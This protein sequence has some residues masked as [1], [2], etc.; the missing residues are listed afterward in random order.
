M[1]NQGFI[2]FSLGYSTLFLEGLPILT[3]DFSLD[4]FYSSPFYVM[5]TI[6]HLLCTIPRCFRAF[7]ASWVVKILLLILL[8]I[9]YSLIVLYNL[10]FPY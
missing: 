2:C 6:S 8:S 3:P 5:L 4:Q 9:V 10:L 1:S 7:L